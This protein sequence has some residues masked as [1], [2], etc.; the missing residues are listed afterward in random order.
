MGEPEE[1]LVC[2]GADIAMGGGLDL[3]E[4]LDGMFELV[5]LEGVGKNI[6]I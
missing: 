5:C 2:G 6:L 1:L 4:E 3:V